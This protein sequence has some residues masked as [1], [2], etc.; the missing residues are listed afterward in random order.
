MRVVKDESSPASS[1]LMR[2][3]VLPPRPLRSC[4]TTIFLEPAGAS[5]G[6]SSGLAATVVGP[7]AV[8]PGVVGPGG[9]AAPLSAANGLWV[10]AGPGVVAT[11]FL[12]MAGPA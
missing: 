8:G 7:G 10:S 4:R 11:G 1:P 2:V 9:S 6:S 12:A 5:R 3:T